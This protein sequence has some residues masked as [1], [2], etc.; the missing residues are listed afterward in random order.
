MEVCRARPSVPR[1]GAN[2]RVTPNVPYRERV[3]PIVLALNWKVGAS[4]VAFGA[5]WWITI[6]MGFTEAVSLFVAVG[7]LITFGAI[8]TRRWRGRR[9]R[10]VR[11]QRA[12]RRGARREASLPRSR[13]A[14][15][16]PRSVRSGL[17]A[18]QRAPRADADRL[19][20][21]SRPRG[22]RHARRP[23][24]VSASLPASANVAGFV[25]ED[26]GLDAVAELQF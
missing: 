1:S 13:E 10:T 24:T 5:L 8:R 18:D 22:R 15:A 3:M 25:G 4:I 26:D 23:V 17:D 9:A 7:A 6:G 12:A 16:Q 2:A 14:S 19:I 11:H 21:R 20:G